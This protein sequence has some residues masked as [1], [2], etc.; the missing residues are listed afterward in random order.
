MSYIVAFITTLLLIVVL[1]QV[2]PFLGI[3]DTPGGH[4]NHNGSIPLVG[5]LAIFG[6][7][8]LSSAVASIGRP[9]A[10]NGVLSTTTVFW[11]C[12]FLLVVVGAWDDKKG[13]PVRVRIAAQIFVVG[14]MVV[15]GGVSVATIGNMFA[16]NEAVLGFWVVPVTFIGVIGAINAMNM[17]DGIDGLAG[18]LA[19]VTV[20]ALAYLVMRSG[21]DAGFSYLVLVS[22]GGAIIAFLIFNLPVPGRTHATVF[23]GDAGSMLLGFVLAWLMT[24]LSQGKDAVMDPVTALWIFAVPL[25]DAVGNMLRRLYTGKSPFG[26][27]REHIHHLLLAKGL[28]VAQVVFV[29]GLFA[30]MMA[31]IGITGYIHEFPQYLMFYGFLSIFGVYILI[32]EYYWRCIKE[33]DPKYS[34]ISIESNRIQETP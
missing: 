22:L 30:V 25:F 8:L 20:A 28:T 15:I 10:V 18:T 21:V 33:K 16:H 11:A 32:V 23:L 31:T 12:T 5:G 24:D 1:K 7:L 4:K 9:M 34:D 17:V 3:L 26:A 14:L 29:I 2:S 19:L 27:D 13:L 6:G